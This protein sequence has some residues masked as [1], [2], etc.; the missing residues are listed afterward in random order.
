[1]SAGVYAGY[2]I[3]F[4]CSAM[5]FISHFQS[6]QPSLSKS[7]LWQLRGAPANEANCKANF[8]GG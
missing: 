8:A 4:V 5:T 3:C 1:M 6:V 2:L 7:A